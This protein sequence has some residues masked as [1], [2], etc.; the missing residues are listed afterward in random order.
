MV[1]NL[2]SKQKFYQTPDSHAPLAKQTANLHFQQKLEYQKL[3]ENLVNELRKLVKVKDSCGFACTVCNLGNFLDVNTRLQ[4]V[5][6]L[7]RDFCRLWNV[8]EWKDAI[9]A[10]SNL[11]NAKNVND[12]LTELQIANVELACAIVQMS[13]EN[14]F[15]TGVILMRDLNFYNQNVYY[16]IALQTQNEAHK[17]NPR[18]IS[19]ILAQ[20]SKQRFYHMKVFETCCDYARQNM[21]AFRIKSIFDIVNSCSLVGHLD[22]AFLSACCDQILQLEQEIDVKLCVQ[23]MRSCASLGYSHPRLFQMGARQVNKLFDGQIPRV[24]M[25]LGQTALL[26]ADDQL[27]IFSDQLLQGKDFS[28][29]FQGNR[30]DW[31]FQLDDKIRIAAGKKV[32]YNKVFYET[33]SFQRRV[34]NFLRDQMDIA[35]IREEYIVEGVGITVDAYFV[36][37]GYRW[38]VEVD[39]PSHFSVNPPYVPIRS[40]NIRDQILKNLGILVIKIPFFEWEKCDSDASKIWYLRG[41][42]SGMLTLAQQRHN[43]WENWYPT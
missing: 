26:L 14:L 30:L 18:E 34:V 36:R 27:E 16:A 42:L 24:L 15:H 39:G 9:S 40:T 1:L 21:H 38:V 32:M 23:F 13:A 22:V 2:I 37:G 5:I 33:S 41:K 4:I 3:T 29:Q 20:F 35:G 10:L 25:N 8:N 7:V 11:Q 28:N 43:D 12:L 6:Q 19:F 17:L 31:W